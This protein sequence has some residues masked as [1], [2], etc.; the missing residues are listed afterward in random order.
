MVQIPIVN[1]LSGLLF[2]PKY[3]ITRPDGT[4]V[5]LFAKN[6]SIMGR[7]FNV[8]KKTDFQ[9]GEEQRIVLGL[10]MMVLLERR[11]G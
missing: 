7:R 5:A 6:P 1:M 9:S 4:Q 2:N 3:S 11:R 8:L 10:M